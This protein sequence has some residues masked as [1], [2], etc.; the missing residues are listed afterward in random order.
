MADI[1]LEGG[2]NGFGKSYITEGERK[3]EIHPFSH[4]N[5]KK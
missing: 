4:T 2:K 1:V 3:D 5:I